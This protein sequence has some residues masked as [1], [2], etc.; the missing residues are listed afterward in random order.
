M[1]KK[2]VTPDEFNKFVQNIKIQNIVLDKLQVSIDREGLSKK[3]HGGLPVLLQEEISSPFIIDESQGIF[4]VSHK[5][6]FRTKVHR[7]I[8]MRIDSV[9]TAIY[10]V[11]P[12]D[13]LKNDYLEIFASTNPRL[14]IWP[15][16]RELLQSLTTRMGLPPFVLP[17]MIFIPES[18]QDKI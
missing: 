4:G 3:K 11:S 6:K 14:H 18:E 10:K 5:V 2:N 7:K 17:P 13:L 16:Q 15:Y 8:V 1:N 12:P 9:F